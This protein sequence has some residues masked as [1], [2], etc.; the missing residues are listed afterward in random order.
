MMMMMDSHID[1]SIYAS[2]PKM[3]TM[4]NSLEKIGKNF[5]KFGK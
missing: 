5:V 2:V 3:D 1:D 4:N